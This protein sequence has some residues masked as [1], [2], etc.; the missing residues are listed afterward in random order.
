MEGE[1]GDEANVDKESQKL[2]W[3]DLTGPAKIRLLRYSS[4]IL[5]KEQLQELWKVFFRLSQDLRVA[6][7]TAFAAQAKGFS[8]RVSVKICYTIHACICNARA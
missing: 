7:A 4:T 3:C 2:R 1:P 8:H 6:D 5:A